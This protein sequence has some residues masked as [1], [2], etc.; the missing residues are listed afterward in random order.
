MR[1]LLIS[2]VSAMAVDALAIPTP[3]NSVAAQPGQTF[4]FQLWHRDVGAGGLPTS[5]FSD[6]VSVVYQ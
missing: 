1:W 6:A 2:L 5:N 4:N 3:S